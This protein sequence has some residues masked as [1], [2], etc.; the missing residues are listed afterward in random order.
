ML[1][2]HQKSHRNR[3]TPDAN[4]FRMLIAH[5]EANFLPLDEDYGARRNY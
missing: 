1:S 2:L 5:S 3:I 4:C